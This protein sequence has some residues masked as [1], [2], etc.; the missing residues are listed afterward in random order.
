MGDIA[1]PLNEQTLNPKI[2]K[3]ALQE[4]VEKYKQEVLEGLQ[5]EEEG[6]TDYI[7]KKTKQPVPITNYNDPFDNL[8]VDPSHKNGQI[9]K[10][11]YSGTKTKPAKTENNNNGDYSFEERNVDNIGKKSSQQKNEGN[12]HRRKKRHQNKRRRRNR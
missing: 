11:S 7:R 6:L 4:E 8:S 3:S 9:L 10:S 5:I 1:I 2:K 12:Q